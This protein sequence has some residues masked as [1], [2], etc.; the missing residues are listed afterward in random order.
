MKKI[1]FWSYIAGFLD[2]D[3]SVYV[4][5]KKNSTY[6]YKF[7]IAPS[8]VFYQ[9]KTDGIGLPEIYKKLALGYLR[10]RNDGMVELVINDRDSIR[11]LLNKTM[12]YLLLKRKQARLMIKILDKMD[13]IITVKD[14]IVLA[15]Y[16]DRFR[17]L[18]YS[19]KR[20]IDT[21]VVSYHLREIG[22]LTP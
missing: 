6:K 21:Q 5:L 10:N 20:T 17:E 15:G 16:V 18:N 2:A 1:Y 22:L 12:P 19:K 4:Q 9:K 14:F 7:Q 8:V 11:R 3:G 13:Q